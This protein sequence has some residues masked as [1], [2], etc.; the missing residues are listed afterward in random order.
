[1]T[2]EPIRFRPRS[3]AVAAAA[4]PVVVSVRFFGDAARW[5]QER[6]HWSFVSATIMDS[7]LIATYHPENLDQIA[8][9]ILGWGA[10]AEVIAPPELRTHLRE[11][12]LAVAE[13][14]T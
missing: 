9:W 11:I 12:A 1:L 6:Q 13:L 2:I 3:T 4:V 8:S 10:G 5:V 14:L 7:D